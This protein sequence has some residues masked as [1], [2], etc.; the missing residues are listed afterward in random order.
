VEKIV[1]GEV[2]V[3]AVVVVVVVV[4]RISQLAQSNLLQ[5]LSKRKKL[6]Q[7]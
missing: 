5:I 2:V 4:E 6:K 7:V 3:I 1:V